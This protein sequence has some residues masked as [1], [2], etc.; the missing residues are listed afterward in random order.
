MFTRFYI[1]FFLVL[2]SSS[3]YAGDVY[4]PEA[5][6]DN[7]KHI[8][9]MLLSAFKNLKWIFAI[10]P[11]I[12]ISYITTQGIKAQIASAKQDNQQKPINYLGLA[13][14]GIFSFAI[15]FVSVF[16][17][18]GTFAVIFAN[19]SDFSDAWNHI[20]QSFWR[21]TLSHTTSK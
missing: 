6:S 4:S 20:V 7:A 9:E 1:L 11:I 16:I 13:T 3:A 21:E 14:S 2:L 18:L 8:Y 15:A 19:A 17:I 10:L 12:A 5:M